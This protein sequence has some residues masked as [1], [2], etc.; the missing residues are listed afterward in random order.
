MPLYT[1]KDICTL[2]RRYKLTI[3]GL[4]TRMGITHTRVRLVRTTGLADPH[5]LRDW[6]EAITGSDPGPLSTTNGPS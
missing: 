1:G 3:A 2:M 6:I 4:A 5:Y